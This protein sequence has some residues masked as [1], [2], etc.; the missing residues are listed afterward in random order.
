MSFNSSLCASTLEVNV[1]RILMR[2][3]FKTAYIY[4]NIDVL[5]SP[6]FDLSNFIETSIYEERA[7]DFG[8]QGKPCS[9]NKNQSVACIK[10]QCSSILLLIVKKL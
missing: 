10:V 2:I 1:Y 7:I 4:I 3:N 6:F 5:Y 8:G 9:M